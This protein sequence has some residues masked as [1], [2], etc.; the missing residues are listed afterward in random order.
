MGVKERYE[1]KMRNQSR[2]GFGSVS[3]SGGV[4]ERY[5]RKRRYEATDT[6]RVNYEYVDGFLKDS[7]RFLNSA[8]REY[9]GVQWG[10]ATSTHDSRLQSWKELNER[11]ETIRAWMYKNGDSLDAKQAGKLTNYLDSFYENGLSVMGAFGDAKDYFSQW[12]SEEAYQKAVEQTKADQQRWQELTGGYDVEKNR[13]AGQTGW[14]AYVAAEKEK[15]A[16]IK[17]RKEKED[18]KSGFEKFLEYFASAGGP[19]TSLPVHV[20][21]QKMAE[22]YRAQEAKLRTPNDRWTE[23]QRLTF[24][25][26]WNTERSK[27]W[28]YAT[29][30]NNMLNTQLEKEKIKGIQEWATDNFG[31]GVAGTIGAVVAV[32]TGIAEF[33]DDMMAYGTLGYIPEAD[34]SITPFEYSQ[35]VTGGVSQHLNDK[36]GTLNEN[37][38]VIGGKGWGDVYGLGVSVGQSAVGGKILGKFGTLTSFFGASAAAGVDDA[39]SR[40]ATDEQALIFGSIS[41]AAEVIT[42]MVP[43]DNLMNMGKAA[44][45]KGLFT[46]IIK[47]GGEEFLG[48]GANS[49]ITN[50]ADYLTLGDKSNFELRKRQYM[51]NGFSQQEAAKKAFT[52]TVEDVA[53]DALGGFVTGTSSAGAFGTANAMAEL[54]R[55]AAAGKAIMGADGGLEALKQ[56]A[57]VLKEAKAVVG[58]DTG[59][60]HLSAGMGTPTIM[61]MGPTD[62]NRNGPYGQLENAIEVNRPCKYCWKRACPHGFDCLER[63][64]PEQVEEKL[65]QYL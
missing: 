8:Q 18:K 33:L 21:Q 57:Y 32:P 45:W 22:G 14:E 35:A 44:D 54:S 4:A 9:D 42:E 59:P 20:D 1:A 49:V 3:T 16:N 6:S 51:E 43:L 58:G 46:D 47:Q 52:D 40:G 36:F 15:E 12:D 64:K 60:V 31:S 27:A 17:A 29:A 23:E 24:G 37:I 53:F 30:V 55:K 5:E 48:E 56:L 26:L 41:G 61:V 65:Q 28:T 19:D 25:Y 38:P 34:G 62:A 13:Q 50:V 39:K 2:Y 11:S 10:N 7:E 63:I